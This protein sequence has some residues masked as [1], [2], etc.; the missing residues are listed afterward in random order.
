MKLYILDTD[1]LTLAQN[2]EPR[3]VGRIGA[4]LASQVATTI[5]SVEEQLDG[6]H[7]HLKRAR[8]DQKRAVIYERFTEGVKYLSRL[9]LLTF[10]QAA[11]ARY[12]R[13]KS[14]KLNIGK[15]DL[16]IAAIALEQ[17]A[18]LVTRNLRDFRRVPAL[19]VDDWSV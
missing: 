4:Q 9:H 14:L 6:W 17:G 2:A 7:G 1:I 3:V 12:A 8:S 10:T 15:M 18:T 13:L 5:L 16:S 19:Q 11:T